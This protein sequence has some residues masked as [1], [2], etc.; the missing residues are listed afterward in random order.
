VWA[1]G[2]TVTWALAATLFIGW[3]DT[4]K[5]YRGMIANLETA[6]PSTYGCMASRNLGDPQRAMLH[7]FGGIV[8]RRE[9]TATPASGCELI[10]V[11]GVP[12]EE[13]APDGNWIK[14]WEGNRLGDKGERFRLYRRAGAVN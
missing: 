9:T 12:Q 14:I 5:S 13:R 10:L 8:T 6:L 2:V 3:V 11:Q 1:A 4:G 7:Y